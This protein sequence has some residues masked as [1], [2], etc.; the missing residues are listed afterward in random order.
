MLTNIKILEDFR[1]FKKD[2]SFEIHPG[3][4]LLVGDQG[5][6]KSSLIELLINKNRFDK[7]VELD[8]SSPMEVRFF[9]FEKDNPRTRGSFPARQELFKPHLAAQLSSHGETVISVIK[10]VY[11]TVGN[12]DEKYIILM[13]E[14]DMAL[15][16]RSI[17]KL[18]DIFRDLVDAKGVQILASVHNP[19]LIA[20]FPEVL[21]LEHLAWMSSQDFISSHKVKI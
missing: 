5:T 14:P 18:R 17:Y 4:N 19:L 11:N 10:S 2:T 12:D 16:I 3:V 21:S 15:S 13:D 9:D 1:C 7:T 8:C 6:G 20:S